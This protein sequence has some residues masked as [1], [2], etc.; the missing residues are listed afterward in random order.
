MLCTP[1][2]KE[3]EMA[4][5]LAMA[6]GTEPPCPTCGDTFQAGDFKIERPLRYNPIVRERQLGDDHTGGRHKGWVHERCS[7]TKSYQH[8]NK[9]R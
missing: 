6:D 3:T 4:L 7:P 1:L 5:K 2:L 8:G 9:R